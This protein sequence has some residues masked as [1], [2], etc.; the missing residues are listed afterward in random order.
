[1]NI[2]ACVF[3]VT[4]LAPDAVEAKKMACNSLEAFAADCEDA[5][6]RVYESWRKV[7]GCRK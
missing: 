2:S 3:D 1:M 7:T 6:A 5:N 4:E